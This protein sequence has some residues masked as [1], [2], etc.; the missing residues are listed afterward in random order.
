M[1][2]SFLRPLWDPSA[3]NCDV[4]TWFLRDGDHL[5]LLSHRDHDTLGTQGTFSL[6]PLRLLHFIHFSFG[7]AY[8]LYWLPR[9]KTTNSRFK[10]G[11]DAL[12]NG[13][14]DSGGAETSLPATQPLHGNPVYRCVFSTHARKNIYRF[15]MANYP[16]KSIVGANICP[17]ADSTCLIRSLCSTVLGKRVCSFLS[18]WNEL[19]VNNRQPL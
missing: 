12:P 19:R 13:K 16:G 6:W 8:F 17:L 11:F 1:V 7:L 4:S 9:A 15:K 10:S 14:H 2:S 3:S 5:T 18:L